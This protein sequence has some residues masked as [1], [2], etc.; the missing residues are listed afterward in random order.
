M[1]EWFTTSQRQY[2]TQ[3]TKPVVLQGILYR[4][5]QDNRFCWI[6]QPKQVPTN[7]QELHGG[8]GRGHFSF[9]IIVRKILDAGY[10]WL[11]MNR[12]VHEYYRTCVQC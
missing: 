9:N 5:G 3:R 10:W 11:T 2:L 1:A 7:L 6:L 4:F 8:V 12:D